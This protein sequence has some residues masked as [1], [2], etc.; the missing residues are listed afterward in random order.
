MNKETE[1]LLALS[2]SA[3][4]E[5]AAQSSDGVYPGADLTAKFASEVG[6]D[7]WAWIKS[8]IQAA[9]FSGIHVGD[10]I[11]FTAG[12]NAY[13][14]QVAGIDSYSKYGDSV[15]PHHIDF[16]C[17]KLWSES[18]A[19][20]QADY[21][22]GIST[23]AAPWLCSDLYFWLNSLAGTVPT[24]AGTTTAVDYTASG[25]FG[26]LPSALQAVIA[27]K[28]MYT[29]TRYSGGGLLTDSNSNAWKNIGKLWLPTELETFGI[30]NSGSPYTS[31][32]GSICQYPIF[33]GKAQVKYRAGGGRS[34]YWL[35][36]PASGASNSFCAVHSSG[37]ASRAAATTTAFVPI[38]FRIV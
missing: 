31:T 10:Y 4:G 35:L 23:E 20:N 3:S 2:S 9:N 21:N 19:F 38:C 8:R 37:F 26:K 24:G 27:E 28:S 30:C 33:R 6:S 36:N 13:C 29:E 14:A 7:A 18:H 34:T 25:V 11:P 15:L 16:I 12:G 22:N 1:L 5:T 17:D 32:R